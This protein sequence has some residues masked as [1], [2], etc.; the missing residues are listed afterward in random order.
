ML[1]HTSKSSPGS[2]PLGSSIE[3]AIVVL[4]SVALIANAVRVV[5]LYGSKMPYYDDWF[6]LAD[7]ANSRP[8]DW[9]WA[10]AH[11][12][13]HV[14]P[15]ER[16]AVAAD[17]LWTDGNL[18]PLLFSSVGFLSVAA[19]FSLFVLNRLRGATRI[20]D[21]TVPLALL[22]SHAH[23]DSM[24][25]I[26]WTNLL[27][28][29]LLCLISGAIVLIANRPSP[30]SLVAI[31]LSSSFLAYQGGPGILYS[32]GLAPSIGYLGWRIIRGNS[33]RGALA[34]ITAAFVFAAIAVGIALFLEA[35][36]MISGEAGMGARRRVVTAFLN[37]TA[38]GF[39]EVAKAHLGVFSL[40]MPLIV[41]TT[42]GFGLS[43]GNRENPRAVSTV[44]LILPVLVLCA[45]IAVSRTGGSGGFIGRYVGMVMPIWCSLAMA[46]VTVESQGVL[47][48]LVLSSSLLLA[49]TS[50][51]STDLRAN[52]PDTRLATDLQLEAGIAAGHSAERLAADLSAAYKVF[53]PERFA[54]QLM[55][56]RSLRRGSLAC[57]E[58]SDE[59]EW[60]SIPA[61][62]DLTRNC[63]RQE[64]SW[65]VSE[66]SL[67]HF[68]VADEIGAA[69]AVRI[70]FDCG[71]AWT[72]SV[73]GGPTPQVSGA[74]LG[75]KLDS[76]DLYPAGLGPSGGGQSFTTTFAFDDPADGFLFMPPKG[77]SPLRI[78]SLEVGRRIR[79]TS[80]ATPAG[81]P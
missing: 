2:R 7:F 80:D 11:H 55:A 45:A 18:R 38:H 76:R 5:W 28:A 73:A 1:E 61:I 71:G 72:A 25:A 64:A 33:S 54:E 9:S 57:I 59:F 27:A 19:I 31:L 50:G 16:L 51:V 48:V 56:I 66:G 37:M 8:G 20:E 6:L 17:W 42:I 4:A 81:D 23:S 67:M 34:V 58:E 32:I 13:A 43:R 44:L 35:R 53:P 78:T 49:A 12:N 29:A 24:W 70:K 3:I 75:L 36:I 65:L 15:L 21:M 39:G 69:D 40:L 63:R 77:G 52:P 14:L 74:Y 62:P 79:L 46:A 60:R 41:L 30:R 10:F 22:G 26:M 47:R 68:P